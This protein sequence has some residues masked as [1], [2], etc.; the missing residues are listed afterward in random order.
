MTWKQIKVQFPRNARQ[1]VL[2]LI[3]L[4]NLTRWLWI[5][6]Q[7]YWQ[8]L[9]RCV[10]TQSQSVLLLLA[11]LFLGKSRGSSVIPA[12]VMRGFKHLDYE[13][14]LEIATDTFAFAT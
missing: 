8:H 1:L 9:M 6:L 13:A 12:M 11:E 2:L 5:R 10:M 7:M 4:Q 3:S 14:G